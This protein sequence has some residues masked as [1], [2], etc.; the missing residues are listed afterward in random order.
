MRWAVGAG[1]VNGSGEGMLEP[2]NNATRA[3]VAQIVLN[4]ESV[5]R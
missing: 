4:C 3:Q 5:R 2:N 1:I